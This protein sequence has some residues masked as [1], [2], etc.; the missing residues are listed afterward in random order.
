M[1]LHKDRLQVLT[2]HPGR[3]PHEGFPRYTINAEERLSPPTDN[4]HVDSPALPGRGKT[5]PQGGSGTQTTTKQQRK[6]LESHNT[7]K[8]KCR[9]PQKTA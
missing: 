6:R 2:D 8:P 5:Q 9:K 3:G 7:K 1:G 4:N